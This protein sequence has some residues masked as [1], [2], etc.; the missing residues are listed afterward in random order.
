[1][2]NRVARWY[3]FE[4]KVQI[5]VNL[6]GP[7]NEKS[8]YFL[9]IWNVSP[10]F[11]ILNKEKSDNPDIYPTYHAAQFVQT[12]SR[13]CSPGGVSQWKGDQIGRFFEQ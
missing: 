12:A 6:G 4:S 3:V 11:G 9:V 13:V 7:W 10:R 8:W 5:W 2:H 1:M